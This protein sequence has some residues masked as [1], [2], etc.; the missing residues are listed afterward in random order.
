VAKYKESTLTGDSW[1]RAHQ[2]IC[3]NPLDDVPSIAFLE[4]EVFNLSTGDVI[5]KN[6]TAPQ[7]NERFTEDNA[8]HEFFLVNPVTG[9]PTTAT[10]TYQDLYVILY[11]IYLHLAEVRDRGPKPY[12]SWIYNET[13]QQ[14]EAPISMPDDGQNYVWDESTLSW[15]L[16][17]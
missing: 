5:R 8:G 4:E 7:M 12:P 6:S 17:E 3:G 1:V 9:E 11:S 13:I 16:A 10:A 2:I 15:I 14:W